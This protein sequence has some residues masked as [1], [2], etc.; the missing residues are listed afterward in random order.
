MLQKLVRPAL[1]FNDTLV[2]V[3]VVSGLVIS[4][5]GWL[6]LVTGTSLA[7]VAVITIGT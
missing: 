4:L 5:T 1:A 7:I 2:L 3:D 6:W